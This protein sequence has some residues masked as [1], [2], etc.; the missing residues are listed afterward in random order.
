[1]SSAVYFRILRP[2]TYFHSQD[3]N[4][5]IEVVTVIFNPSAVSSSKYF[6]YNLA[7]NR[8]ILNK[9]YS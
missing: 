6:L 4:P 2:T 1:M 5:E 8:S 7:A 3:K 9:K